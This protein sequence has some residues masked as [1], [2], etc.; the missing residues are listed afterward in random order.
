MKKKGYL[1]LKEADENKE[2]EFELAYL[3]SLTVAQRFSLVKKKNREIKKLLAQHGHRTT[4][5][6]IK[7]K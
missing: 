5:K 3:A 1:L 6:I 4:F 2:I 7:R